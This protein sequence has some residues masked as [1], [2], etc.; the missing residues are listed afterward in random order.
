MFREEEE[1]GRM[2]WGI[3]GWG[4]SLDL[5]LRAQKRAPLRAV[6]AAVQR[7]RRLRRVGEIILQAAVVRVDSNSN[8]NMDTALCDSASQKVDGLA[9]G[10]AYRLLYRMIH[11]A[12]LWARGLN[13]ELVF[14]E[15]TGLGRISMAGLGNITRSLSFH[16]SM[17]L[18]LRS[19][20]PLDD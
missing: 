14:A 12:H 8:S 6:G 3:S 20:M 11:G 9:A 2:E 4:F 5:G 17:P 1:I 19:P 18:R 7:A 10:F 16:V 13:V 15:A